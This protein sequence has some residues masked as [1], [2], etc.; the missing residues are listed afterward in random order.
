MS[1]LEAV[2]SGGDLEKSTSTS[3]VRRTEAST[4]RTQA[5]TMPTSSVRIRTVL[6]R[7]QHPTEAK[8][9]AS[10]SAVI[11]PRHSNQPVSAG[12]ESAHRRTGTRQSFGKRF[13]TRRDR[14]KQKGLA[15]GEVP[16]DTL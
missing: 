8:N 7:P 16:R 13:G 4:S 10:S 2:A 12:S 6:P 1:R 9:L 11:R 14:G 5:D 15:Q 3:W